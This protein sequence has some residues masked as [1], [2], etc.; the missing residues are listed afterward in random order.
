[1]KKGQ[2]SPKRKCNYNA[3]LYYNTKKRFV[4]RF[5]EFFL[6]FWKKFFDKALSAVYSIVFYPS[7]RVKTASL[8]QVTSKEIRYVKTASE[9]PSKRAF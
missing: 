5:F 2:K 3:F 1:L 8:K 6:L 7:Y 9:S 4:K